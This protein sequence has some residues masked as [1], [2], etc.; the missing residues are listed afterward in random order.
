MTTERSAEIETEVT[1]ELETSETAVEITA[2]PVA[3]IE[4]TEDI[5]YRIT[6]SRSEGESSDRGY[7]VFNMPDSDLRYVVIISSDDGSE[8]GYDFDVTD[9][10][11]D[12]FILKITVEEK[13]L[14]SV[15]EKGSWPCTSV[16]IDKFPDD[17]IVM[18]TDN[19]I[20]DRIYVYMRDE[21]ISDDY[22]AVFYDDGGQDNIF[23]YELED[24]RYKW[25][26]ISSFGDINP[27]ASDKI[28]TGFGLAENKEE[29]KKLVSEHSCRI[30]TYPG[31]TDCHTTDEF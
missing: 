29:L 11:F 15:F 2:K 30:F 10:K 7:Y 1:T 25:L 17:V 18:T 23:V 22:T 5:A 21:E 26:V 31:E 19:E 6:K 16:E 12:G 3:E 9:V 28:I 27:A 24:G 8:N 13:E 14:D 4:N 20:L